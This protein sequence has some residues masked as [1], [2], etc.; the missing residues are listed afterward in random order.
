[1]PSVSGPGWAWTDADHLEFNG[2]VAEAIGADG[3][4]VLTFTGQNSCDSRMRPMRSSR[5]ATWKCGATRH[6]AVP[7][8]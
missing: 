4:M 2:Y 3:N 7:G 5:Y 6:F 1:M 8:P